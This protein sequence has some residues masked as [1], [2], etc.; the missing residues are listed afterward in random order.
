MSELSTGYMLAEVAS[1]TRSYVVCP[2]CGGE[3]FRTPVSPRGSGPWSC[4][5]CG[6]EFHMRVTPEGSVEL[7]RTGNVSLRALHLLRRG[8][9]D[10][11]NALYL[12]VQ[13][14]SFQ[15]EQGFDEDTAAYHYNEGTCPVNYLGV[16]EVVEGTTRDPHGCF[17]YVGSLPGIVPSDLQP[18]EK[19]ELLVRRLLE[20]FNVI[21]KADT[22]EPVVVTK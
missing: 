2:A 8:D 15:N 17:E 6:V 18:G 21:P 22:A 16:V 7:R 12:V 1:E 4:P 13:G 10:S 19:K 9:E 20:R 14:V 5:A 11:E 3:G